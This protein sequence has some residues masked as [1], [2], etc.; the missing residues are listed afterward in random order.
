MKTHQGWRSKAGDA[1]KQEHNPQDFTD[2]LCHCFFFSSVKSEHKRDRARKTNAALKKARERLNRK[3]MYI[4]V[5]AG[6]QRFFAKLSPVHKRL[7]SGRLK[8]YTAGFPSI[9]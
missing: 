7:E 2:S 6:W 4:R 9:K 8:W 5:A 1:D 3:R